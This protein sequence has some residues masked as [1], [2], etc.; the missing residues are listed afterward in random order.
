MT[1]TTC[2][3]DCTINP[4]QQLVLTPGD[5]SLQQPRTNEFTCELD[6]DNDEH[7]AFRIADFVVNGTSYAVSVVATRSGGSVTWA[8]DGQACVSSAETAAVELTLEVTATPA[9]G[10]AVTGGGVIRIQPTGKPD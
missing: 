9:G 10:S 7:V 5:G 8:R 3:I 4:S 2:A 1:T 6:T